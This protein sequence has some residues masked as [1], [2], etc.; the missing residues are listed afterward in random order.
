MGDETTNHQVDS[1]VCF[2]RTPVANVLAVLGFAC[3]TAW[4]IYLILAP[5]FPMLSFLPLEQALPCLAVSKFAEI[6]V[7]LVY[8]RRPL[9]LGTRRWDALVFPGAPLLYLP[10][11]AVAVLG[12]AAPSLPLFPAA[13]VAW[14]LCGL[15]DV[16]L[17]LVW[18]R[19][20]GLMEPRRIMFTVAF[21]GA[22]ATPFF[23][24]VAN[25]QIA[26]LGLASA[27]FVIGSCAVVTRFL[28]TRSFDAEG[29]RG[30]EGAEVRR[31]AALL[32]LRATLSVAT[33]AVVYGY[34]L[35]ILYS[36]GSFPALLAGSVGIVSSGVA[37]VWAQRHRRESWSTGDS[38]RMTV[39]VVAAAVLLVPLC[40]DVGRGVCAATA[41]G[42]LSYTSLM[43][44]TGA[45]TASAEFLLSPTK[46]QAFGRFAQWGG[47]L[48]GVT[49]A[50]VVFYVVDFD[51]LQLVALSSALAV[52]VVTAFAAY[53]GEGDRGAG[54][55]LELVMD[56]GKELV[57]D[58]PKNATPFRDRCEALAD[59]CGLTPRER[60]VFDCLARGRN[61]EYIQNKLFI[62]EN[63]VRTHILHIYRK[64]EVNSQQQ[65]IDLVD[66]RTG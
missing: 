58:P 9:A 27:A 16:A 48:V 26:L 31:E 37:A 59:R 19:L 13:L 29:V 18:M 36:L 64:L 12:W 47:F 49:V 51:R 50:F 54:S 63:T 65:L 45:A 66:L 6:G 38:Q 5:V 55:L 4:G 33:C 10:A 32:S 46:R 61:A 28:L 34:L 2:M 24:F 23:L 40:D 43:E 1:H 56:G 62:S 53:V 15:G 14:A 41:I 20:M 3:L 60:E 7:L 11:F 17:P 21:A 57:V 25:A 42:A 8:V 39:P 35:T 30:E 44:W 52:A 22:L